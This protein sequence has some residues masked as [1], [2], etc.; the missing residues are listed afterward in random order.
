MDHPVLIESEAQVQQ[1]A[2]ISA[3]WFRHCSDFS[4]HGPDAH[5]VWLN[6]AG[7]PSARCSAWWQ[8]TPA[9]DS[10]R[11][12]IIGHYAAQNSSDG[13]RL[14]QHAC[15]ELQRRDVNWAVGP[16][17]GNTWR[18]YRLVVESGSRPP[19]FLEP[20]NPLDW[21]QAWWAAGFTVEATYVSRL[22]T[23]LNYDEPRGRRAAD[24]LR[25]LGVQFRCLDLARFDQEL[26]RLY[27]LITSSFQQN[28]LYSPVNIA[29]F[30]EQYRAIR[31]VLR[32]ELIMIA[33]H[34]DRPVG[35]V[36]TIPD[37]LQAARGEPIDT[38]I[39][40]TLVIAPER[41]YAGLGALL[42]AENQRAAGK[43]GYCQAIHALMHSSNKS[44][45]ISARY[46]SVFR[47]YAL[48][49]KAL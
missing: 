18:R 38:V 17:D 3:G 31:P 45:S 4:Q 12:G 28:L 24:R 42:A 7:S 10:H 11:V 9:Y 46:G 14:L 27:P 20:D 5:W 15:K 49:A 36:F 8:R 35:L 34:E 13:A 37:F 43:L 19:F 41:A 2:G 6:A 30:I 44:H 25:E 26:E 39:I 22:N 16:I 48:F 1:L 47:R 32:P 33:E 29:D 23:N 21:P 40:K